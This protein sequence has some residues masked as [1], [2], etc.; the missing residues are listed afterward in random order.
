M[1]DDFIKAFIQHETRPTSQ[2]AVFVTCRKLPTA[3]NGGRVLVLTPRILCLGIEL[4]SKLDPE[5]AA[6]V[7]RTSLENHL[8][9]PASV[10]TIAVSASVRDSDIVRKIADQ[11][12]ASVTAYSGKQLADVRIPLK[13]TFAPERENDVATAAAYLASTEGKI[14]IRRS[15]GTSGVIFSAALRKGNIVIT[16]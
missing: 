16:D 4:K 7:V 14:V 5:Y 11:L 10:S 9:E 15:G 3:E 1:H 8:I 13:M 6:D 2:P 12:G